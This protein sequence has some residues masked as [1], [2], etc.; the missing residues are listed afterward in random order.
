MGGC[1][2][3]EDGTARG[4]R[5]GKEVAEQVEE[6]ELEEDQQ[7]EEERKKEAARM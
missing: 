1:R 5:E 3:E 2:D 6:K 7:E 4:A